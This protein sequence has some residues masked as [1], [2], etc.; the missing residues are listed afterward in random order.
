MT[1]KVTVVKKEYRKEKS[2]V[3][4]FLLTKMIKITINICVKEKKK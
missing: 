1:L 4:C 2:R 3:W